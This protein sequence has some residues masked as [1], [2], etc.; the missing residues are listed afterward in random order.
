VCE[1]VLHAHQHAL[2]HRD[3]KPSNI[4]VT[5]G[6]Q[7]KLLDFGI[8]K[9]LDRSALSDRTATGMPLLTPAYAAP[10]QFRGEG[11]GVHSDIYSLGAILYE[12]ATG[13]APL[14]VAGLG[15]AAAERV[16]SDQTPERPSVA[17]RRGAERSAA[18]RALVGEPGGLWAD[19]DVLC[20]TALEKDPDR[21]YRSVDALIRD[22]DH[23]LRGEPLDARPASLAYRAGKFV[24]RHRGPVVAGTAGVL[25][26]V[27]LTVYYTVNLARAR[28]AAV[29]EAERTRRIQ[30]FMNGLF[31][32]GDD[33]TG[34]SDTLRVVTLLERGVQEAGSL[35]REPAIQAE[36]HQTL[37]GIF[38]A[39]GHLDRADRLQQLALR[40]RRAELGASHPDVVRSLLALGL[41]RAHQARLDEADSLV[42]A[43]LDLARRRARDDPAAVARATTALGQVLEE[44]GDYDGAIRALEEAARLDSAAGLPAGEASSTLTELA[45]SHFYAGHYAVADSL[46]RRLLAAD[47]AAYGARHPRVAGGLINLGAVR[48]EMGDWAGAE[49]Y[50]RQALE[51]YR[52]WY[53]EDHFET[54]AAL[55]MVGRARVQQ[56]RLGE[57]REPL[58][59]ALAVRERIYG[60]DHVRVASTLN[61]L[62]LLAQQDGRFE[63]AIAHF[64]RMIAIYERA[65][66][67]RHFLI[68]LS[69]ANLG[70]VHTARG[71]HAASEA[72]YR[73][74]I[75]EYLETLPPGHLYVGV[76]RLKL[77]RALMRQGRFAEGERESR[78]GYEIVARQP[79]P[80]HGWLQNAR[81]DLAW[82][83]DVLGRPADAARFRDEM[84]RASA[85]SA[86]RAAEATASR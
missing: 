5:R 77:G 2:L 46:N 86:R 42:R 31:E 75:A 3:L 19:L 73:R 56:G 15:P 64:R 1:A 44:R 21:R 83:S 76:A 27:A 11:L 79:E 50:Y 63:D 37:G 80:A 6:G 13:R 84:N 58:A 35:D 29:A 28:D 17:A 52:G 39:L 60:R 54:A 72:L 69:L 51:I 23:T 61:E 33:A 18:I 53:G 12:L 45:N 82:A 47:R 41:L 85:D 8:A 68:G 7:P 9:P 34:P 25:V 67:G 4:L 55:N 78:A 71:D 40:Q 48:Q 65:Y 26:I 22:V 10:E 81:R 14:E 59:R 43:G 30:R 32:G 20:L 49:R 62:G 24:R 16:V 36:L 38:E 70:S 66:D 74:A 57:A